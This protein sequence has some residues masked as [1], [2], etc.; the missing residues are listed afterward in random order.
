MNYL[1]AIIFLY[2]FF[3]SE[4]NTFI[5]TLEF[6][7]LLLLSLSLV[8]TM[9]RGLLII[10]FI[11]L[12]SATLTHF[13][14][15]KK[16]LGLILVSTA[17]L[18]IST[19]LI[20]SIQL[21]SERYGSILTGGENA[22]MRLYNWYSSVS[23]IKNYP[24]TGVG[25]GNDTEYLKSNLPQFSPEIVQKFGGDTPHNEFFHFGIQVGILGMLFVIFFYSSL[26]IKSFKILTR[27]NFKSKFLPNALFSISLGISVWSI[28][29]DV[30]LAGNGYF[31]ILIMVFID[32]INNN[33]NIINLENR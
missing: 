20:S 5:K 12:L 18:I 19:T 14:S 7:F 25:L 6:L 13:I 8:L 27:S 17:T 24:F 28:A 32:K 29:N 30:L 11:M 33:H 4:K 15:M 22:N 3:L 1:Y 21:A 9:G 26:I 16:Y 23:I 2:I 31:E 10:T